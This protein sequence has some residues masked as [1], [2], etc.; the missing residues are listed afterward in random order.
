M[1]ARWVFPEADEDAAA[2]MMQR[3]GLPDF[4]A[5][6]LLSRGVGIEQ[7]PSFLFPTL[8]DHFPDPFAMA[9]MREAAR[10]LADAVEA[11]RKIA[12][13]A[14]FDVD[15]A[16]SSG[17]LLRFLRSVG[18][19]PLLYIPDRLKEGY[20]ANA[21]A[22]HALKGQ[23]A[24]LVVLCDCGI[25]AHEPL[26]EAR[27]LGLETIVLD[28][29]EPDATLPP[30]GHIVNPKRADDS[31]GFGMLAACGVTFLTCVAVNALL[32]ER[33]FFAK[34][35]QTEPQLKNWL[36][37]V[38]LGTVCDM[39]PLTGPNR[40]FVRSGME[41]MARSENPGIRALLAVSRIK[42]A[43]S[44]YDLGFALGPRINAGGRID[45]AD[46]GARLL[47]CDDPEEAQSIALTL[48][49]CNRKRREMQAQMMDE[50]VRRIEDSGLAQD[51][52]ILVHDPGWHPGL[53]GLVA[54]RLKD[55][56]NKPACV[57]AF[58]PDESGRAEGR[59]SGRS[60][61]G[62]SI[63][64]AF[65]DAKAA[66]LLVKGGG[67][68]MAGGF[69]ILPEKIEAFRAFLNTHV[70]GQMQSESAIETR[71]DGVLSVRGAKVDWVRLLHERIG[72]FGQGHPEPVFALPGVRVHKADIV[73]TDHVRVMLG[74]PEGGAWMKA[75]AF[76][77]A[78]TLLGRALLEGASD[79]PMHLAGT[80][81]IDGWG[82]RD[83]VEMHI[84]DGSFADPAR[85]NAPLAAAS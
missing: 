82:G 33:G 11:G 5:R 38:A 84:Q 50:A 7:V 73:G 65:L 15:G 17:V 74:D 71:I 24:E 76:K 19:D 32:R 16:T 45:K 4:I 27:A 59:G 64:A 40:L 58:T 43:P 1:K 21:R 67:H 14:D 52:V 77:S 55:L 29:H 79:A 83:K 23:G 31:S 75:V 68:A 44:P 35:G 57:V 46:L 2:R 53:A 8:R 51:P 78:G 85:A 63:A 28:H 60:V 69:T 34:N 70:S 39:V 47:S 72:P 20:G 13:F 81:K 18:S 62:V 80:L 37:I 61:P 66:G 25:T 56:H 42:G 6:L 9:G 30:A 48:D 41:R 54:G 49:E 12:V 10:A 36:D 22:F 26:A 3:H